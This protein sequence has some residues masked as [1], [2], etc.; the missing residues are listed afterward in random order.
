MIQLRD[1][2]REYKETIALNGIDLDIE[3][4]DYISIVGKSGAGKS[5]LLNILAGIDVPTS[6]NYYFYGKKLSKQ[7]QKLARFRFQNIGLI[8]QNFALISTM[9]IL[10]NVALPLKYRGDERRTLYHQVEKMLDSFGILDKM[11]SYPEQLSGGECQRAALA[12][13]L[14]CNP[15]ILLAD[16]PTGSL[17]YENKQQIIE[18][19]NELN[20]AG[21]TIVVVTH[22]MEVA[23]QAAQILK[24]ENGQ[25]I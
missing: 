2:R 12:R 20:S 1:I 13:A 4:G 19:L 5:T 17:D 18:T 8:V 14:I 15:K 10:E 16:E 23:N 6:G 11:D 21:M 9:T 24:M 22:D 3:E 25:I 7:I